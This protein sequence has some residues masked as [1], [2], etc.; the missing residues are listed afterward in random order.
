MLEEVVALMK[1]LLLQAVL[2]VEEQVD[3]MSQAQVVRRMEQL[4]LEVEQVVT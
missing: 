3:L 4:I 1:A 2:A